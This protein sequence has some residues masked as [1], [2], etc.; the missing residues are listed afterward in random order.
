MTSSNQPTSAVI[1]AIV[2]L[3][4]DARDQAQARRDAAPD[5][6]EERASADAEVAV[7]AAAATGATNTK[8]VGQKVLS[9][10]A[11]PSLPATSK[12]TTQQWV[13]IGI[14]SLLVVFG[15]ALAYLISAGILHAQAC[16]L[17]ANGQTQRCDSNLLQV[18]TVALSL[19]SAAGGAILGLFA[20]PDGKPASA[21]TA[22][23]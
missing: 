7:H 1:D 11:A 3:F 19:A 22:G 16:A 15:F 8:D 17:A 5:G 20:T 9:L 10:T 12:I 2:K 23:K 18:G 21:P 14:G 4:T 13:L 6:T